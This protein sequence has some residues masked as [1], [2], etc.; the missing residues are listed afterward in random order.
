[1]HEANYLE[2]RDEQNN[3]L[4]NFYKIQVELRKQEVKDLIILD[5]GKIFSFSLTGKI[6]EE[7]L[8][9]VKNQHQ[10]GTF[11]DF[12]YSAIHIHCHGKYTIL[13]HWQMDKEI[14]ELNTES[15]A[16]DLERIWSGHIVSNKIMMQLE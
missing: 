10:A 6:V 8:L 13:A 9:N 15:N 16:L 14:F 7:K 1:M 3:K 11:I 4:E 2:I 12:I 5:S